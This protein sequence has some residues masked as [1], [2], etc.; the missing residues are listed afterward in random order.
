MATWKSILFD[1]LVGAGAAL[2]LFGAIWIGGPL[3]VGEY[4][5]STVARMW[6][7]IAVYGARAVAFGAVVGGCVGLSQF[8]RRERLPSE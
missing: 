4:Y 7:I 6:L 3:L 2:V 8:L 5:G 1:A